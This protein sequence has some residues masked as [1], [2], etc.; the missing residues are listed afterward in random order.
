MAHQWN[1]NGYA[2][3]KHYVQCQRCG[4]DYMDD[5]VTREWNGA[6]VCKECFE[7]RHEQEFVRAPQDKIAASGLV[8]PEPADTFV[9]VN[10]ATSDIPGVPDGTNDNGL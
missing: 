9:T 8:N 5:Q 6:I 10:W 1:G 7:T 4:I 3:G 2:P